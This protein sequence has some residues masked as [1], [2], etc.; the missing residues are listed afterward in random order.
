MPEYIEIRVAMQPTK[1]FGSTAADEFI[2]IA[3]EGM[4]KGLSSVRIT[5]LSQSYKAPATHSARGVYEPSIKPPWVRVLNILDKGAV[6]LLARRQV[7]TRRLRAVLRNGSSLH[8]LAIRR[9]R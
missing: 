1:S 4:A 2:G 8:G 6:G 5:C 7:G 3:D 9:T